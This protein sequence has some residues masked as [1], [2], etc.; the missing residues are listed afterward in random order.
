MAYARTYPLGEEDR[1][2]ALFAQLCSVVVNAAGVKK[3]GG[4]QFEA[5]DF[6]LFKVKNFTNPLQHLR[7]LLGSRVVKVTRSGRKH[8]RNL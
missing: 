8:R 2:D 6:L 7:S 3:R 5:K 4:G 1:D